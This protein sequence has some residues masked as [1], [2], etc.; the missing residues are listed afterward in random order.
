[1]AFNLKLLLSKAEYES[2]TLKFDER[3]NSPE[4]L[5]RDISA[6]SNAKGGMILLGVREPGYV[7]GISETKL[8]KC[9]DTAMD[10]I[11]GPIRAEIEFLIVEGKNVGLIHI[12]NSDGIVGSPYGIYRR[13]GEVMA[14]LNAEDIINGVHKDKNINESISTVSKTIF[15]QNKLIEKISFSFDNAN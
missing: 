7:V 14:P 9:F 6:F 2:E 3:I 4:L 1:M 11:A 12:K 13:E 8:K 15:Q 5:A 10:S